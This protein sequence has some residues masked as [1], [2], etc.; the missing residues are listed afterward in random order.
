MGG[1]LKIS[2]ADLRYVIFSGTEVQDSTEHRAIYNECYRL[3]KEVWL[4]TYQEVAQ[5]QKLYSDGFTRQ[6]RIG[7]LFKG[8]ECIGLT[9]LRRADLGLQ[10]SQEDSLL[11]AWTPEAYKKLIRDGKDVAICSYLTV[12]PN[13][14][15]EI[16]PGLMLKFLL[17]DLIALNFLDMG[18][19]VMTGTMRVSRG[20]QKAAY[21]TGATFLCKSQMHKEEAD[22]VAFYRKDLLHSSDLHSKIWPQTLWNR[23]EVL[24]PRV[25]SEPQRLRQA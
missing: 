16:E 20:T 21:A 15:G 13:Y 14:R 8:Q 25:G 1:L 4:A 9:T 22:L 10:A 5:D 18:G 24:L 11:S 12:A 19:D 7:A 2:L 23:R 17:T 3:W 6:T